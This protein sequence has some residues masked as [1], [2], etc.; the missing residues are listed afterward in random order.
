MTEARFPH[1]PPDRGHYESFYLRAVDPARPRGIWIRYTTHQRPGRPPT[2]SLWFT[3]FDAA[4]D[5]PYAVKQTFAAPAL[6]PGG[7]IAIGDSTFGPTG[8]RGRAVGLDRLA[9]WQ[10]QMTGGAE[11]LRHLPREWMYRAPLPRTK[12]E[13]LR[14]DAVFSGHLDVAGERV[15]VTGWPGM[16]GHNWGA[17]HAAAWIWLHGIAFDE[18]PGAW[19]DLSVGRVRVGR[20]LTPWIANGAVEVDGERIR[21]GGPRRAK[22]DATPHGC[23]V[24]VPNA[25]VEAR[26]QPGQTVAWPYADPGGG[27]HHSLNCSIAEL[28]VRLDRPGRPA[29]ELAT[30]HGAAYELGTAADGRH[31]IPVQPF[32]DG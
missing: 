13:T 8:A 10:L 27:E 2:G 22:V 12:L 24:A 9:A 17:E 11:P 4:A 23:R 7:W 20:V 28:R 15:E 26:P 21:L 29:L 31:G 3:Y 6:T 14:P 19:L 16:A 1:V 18:T 32:A 5:A 30:H 25:V